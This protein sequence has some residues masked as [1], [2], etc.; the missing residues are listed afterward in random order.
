MFIAFT[1]ATFFGGLAMLISGFLMLIQKN[2]LAGKSAE[3]GHGG[4]HCWYHLFHFFLLCFLHSY[5]FY[6]VWIV[7]NDCWRLWNH[8][9]S[10]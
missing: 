9:G 2:S 6:R 7:F 10:R 1:L 4:E 3:S 8:T 5:G